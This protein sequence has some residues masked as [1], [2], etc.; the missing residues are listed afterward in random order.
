LFKE[1]SLKAELSDNLRVQRS[2]YKLVSIYPSIRFQ[3]FCTCAQIFPSL[4]KSRANAGW[5]NVT[6]VLGYYQKYWP[7]CLARETCPC[8]GPT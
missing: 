6:F 7:G 2:F 4:S 1:I 3:V 8:H 5:A